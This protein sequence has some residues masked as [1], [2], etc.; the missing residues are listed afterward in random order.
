MKTGLCAVRFPACLINLPILICI[1]QR[2]LGFSSLLVNRLIGRGSQTRAAV[3][4]WV[5]YVLLKNQQLYRRRHNFNLIAEGQ[6]D[7]GF[8]KMIHSGKCLG[9]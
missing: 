3:V 7:Q 4:F 5:K 6:K 8:L 9:S 2:N 1:Y